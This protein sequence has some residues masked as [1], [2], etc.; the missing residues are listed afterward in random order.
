MQPE[1]HSWKSLHSHAARQLPADFPDRVLRA[2]RDSAQV[3]PSFLRSFWR[4]P[5]A[6]SAMTAAACLT[7]AIILHTIES[8]QATEDN[9][10]QWQEITTQTASLDPL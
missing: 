4:H 10:A 2:A 9:L 3:E 1:S 7:I 5:L 8:R 6:I